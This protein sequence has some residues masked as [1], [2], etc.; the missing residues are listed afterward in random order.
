MTEVAMKSITT[1]YNINDEIW[2]AENETNKIFRGVIDKIYITDS[3]LSNNLAETSI[4]YLVKTS[5]ELFHLVPQ[6]L[7]AA[8]RE[9]LL[10]IVQEMVDTSL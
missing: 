6:N 9:D 3:L 2:F 4:K 8:N 1:E 10:D 7:I 5:D